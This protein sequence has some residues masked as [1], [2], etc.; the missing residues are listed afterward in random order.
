MNKIIALIEVLKREI[1]Q[2]C[3]RYCVLKY[4]KE[5]KNLS[6]IKCFGSF[7]EA[8]SFV[9]KFRDNNI[10]NIYC[11]EFDFLLMNNGDAIYIIDMNKEK[12]D[13]K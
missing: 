6:L 5:T 4:S 13:I 8:R 2:E 10:E 7:N 1:E 11:D 9:E 3:K 12:G